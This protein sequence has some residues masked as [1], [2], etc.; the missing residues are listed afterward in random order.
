MLVIALEAAGDEDRD[1]VR[2]ELEKIEDFAGTGGIFNMSAEDHCGLS[3]GCM[4]IVKIEDG[5]W[6][7]AA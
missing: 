2:D 6:V 4:V 7:L 3:E 5:G 1:S